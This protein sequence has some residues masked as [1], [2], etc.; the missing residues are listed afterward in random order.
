MLFF[1]P[2]GTMRHAYGLNEI[3]IQY[4]S[5]LHLVPVFLIPNRMSLFT[6]LESADE[7][8]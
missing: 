8:H 4:Q 2:V 1:A 7:K 3:L 6:L 5:V